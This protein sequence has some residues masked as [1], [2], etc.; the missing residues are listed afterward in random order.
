MMHEDVC[1]T[2]ISNIGEATANFYEAIECCKN[3]D[4]ETAEKAKIAGEEASLVA[5][6]SHAELIKKMANGEPIEMNLL[7]VHAEDQLM[8]AEMMKMLTEQIMH[9]YKE[10]HYLKLK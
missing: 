2:I 8:N 7:L 5:H 4:F 9:L 6:K 3:G 10:I 1:F